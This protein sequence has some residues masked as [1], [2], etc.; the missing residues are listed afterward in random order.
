MN[1]PVRSH[2]FGTKCGEGE[3]YGRKERE[4]RA[5]RREAGG[6]M[7]DGLKET[8]GLVSSSPPLTCCESWV[9]S[10]EP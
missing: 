4:K 9:K 2:L 3:G 6:S 8:V 5:Q 10:H 7:K 1:L